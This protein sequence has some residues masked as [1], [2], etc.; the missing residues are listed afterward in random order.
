MSIVLP[1]VVRTFLLASTAVQMYRHGAAEQLPE[2]FNGFQAVSVQLN[3]MHMTSS[4]WL[5]GDPTLEFSART[6]SNP[7]YHFHTVAGRYV[8][9]SFLGSAAH[10]SV[11]QAV[12]HIHARPQRFDDAKLCFFGVSIDQSDETAGRLR[13]TIPGIRYLWDF[14]RKV[15]HAYGALESATGLQGQSMQYQ[16]FTLVLDPMLRVLAHI[17]MLPVERHNQALDHI[18][19]TLPPVADHAASPLCAPVLIL[20]R[21]LEPELCSELVQLYRR[22][23]GEASG[24]MREIHGKTVAVMDNSFKRR[25]DFAFDTQPQFEKL[26]AAIRARLLRRLVP[27]IRRAFQFQVTRMERYVVACYDSTEGGLFRPHKDNTTLGTAHRRFACTINLN[28]GEYEGGNLRFPEFGPQ[29]Y[30]APTGGA[31]VF[32]CSLLHEATPVISGTRYAFLPFFYDDAAARIRQKNLH[33]LT[34][35]VFDHGKGED[36]G[37]IAA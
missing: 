6:S 25:K 19:A 28:A 20:P 16:P 21:V 11:Q 9:L 26:R 34:G 8:V 17:P 27:E 32:S 7:R 5:P 4:N 12:A 1:A 10:P 18:L 13:D 3:H 23:G 15:S 33:S 30:R 22:E 31:V 2:S 36:E 29:T 14:D 37:S 24:F 35:E